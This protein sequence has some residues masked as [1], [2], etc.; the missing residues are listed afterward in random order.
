MFRGTYEKEIKSDYYHICCNS[1]EQVYYNDTDM[2]YDTGY[3]AINALIKSIYDESL[4]A[5]DEH[6]AEEA[7]R[8]IENW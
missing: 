4:E 3:D 7:I 8:I 2:A 1:A 5:T 6:N